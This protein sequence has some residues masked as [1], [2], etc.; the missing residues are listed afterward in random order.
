MGTMPPA[1][2]VLPNRRPFVQDDVLIE[3]RSRLC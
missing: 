1:R 2:S 3:T